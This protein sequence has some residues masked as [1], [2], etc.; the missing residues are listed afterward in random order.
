MKIAVPMPKYGIFKPAA[1]L[2]EAQD[3][4]QAHLSGVDALAY[5]AFIE[6]NSRAWVDA[7]NLLYHWNLDEL[8]RKSPVTDYSRLIRQVLRNRLLEVEE[9][10]RK[11]RYTLACWNKFTPDIAIEE[12]KAAALNHRIHSH[13]LLDHMSA[14]GLPPEAVQLFLDN[15]YVNNRVFHLHIAAQSLSAPFSMRAEM[16]KNLYDELG[17]GEPS[18]AHPL[19]FLRNYRTLHLP[20]T[21]IP[22]TGSVFLLNTKIYHTF[23]SGNVLQ[24]VGGLG[25]LE[26]AM[27]AQMEKI[28]AGLKKS[29]LPVKDLVFWEVHITL[30]KEHGESWFEEVRD[31]V[32]SREDAKAL[33]EGGMSLLDARARFYD[34]VWGAVQEMIEPQQMSA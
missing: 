23:L 16:Y 21:I 18:E 4:I 11:E 32:R 3:T 26:L 5:A 17:S 29:N 8:E 19:L 13:P 1:T 10:V 34:D 2:A 7:Q 22:L 12:L 30:D 20:D 9:R 27:P 31:L 24:G 28:F 14:E 15:Y 33:F 6:G 25:F